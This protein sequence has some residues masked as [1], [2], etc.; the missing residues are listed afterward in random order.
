MQDSFSHPKNEM[1]ELANVFVKNFLWPGVEFSLPNLINFAQ[2]KDPDLLVKLEMLMPMDEV[3]IH[4]SGE[5]KY[6]KIGTG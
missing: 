6:S 4:L 1:H 5:K 2:N 3:I